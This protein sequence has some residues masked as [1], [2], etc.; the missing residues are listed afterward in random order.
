MDGRAAAHWA[1]TGTWIW[2]MIPNGRLDHHCPGLFCIGS[3]DN[4][5]PSVVLLPVFGV[6]GL[7]VI[8]LIPIILTPFRG[9]FNLREGMLT[10]GH[11]GEEMVDV[12]HSHWELCNRARLFA[13]GSTSPGPGP[14]L[15]H[16]PRKRRARSLKHHVGRAASKLLSNL[17][18]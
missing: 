16:L 5:V 14:L 1:I 17:P 2:L 3:S 15:C 18:T 4:K 7:F 10:V 11:L 9:Y 13:R 8:S 6:A 12:T